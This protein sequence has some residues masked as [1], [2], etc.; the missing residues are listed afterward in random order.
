[1]V[2]CPDV[3]LQTPFLFR[4]SYRRNN[5]QKKRKNV[6]FAF[7]D[8]EKAFELVPRDVVMWTLKKPGM[9]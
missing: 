8:L 9:F 2:S 6:Y 3:E 1:M 7:V 5:Y 4:D